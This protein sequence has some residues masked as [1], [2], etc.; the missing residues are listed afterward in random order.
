MATTKITCFPSLH[1]DRVWPKSGHHTQNS[2]YKTERHMYLKF[3]FWS[4][5]WK[6]CEGQSVFCIS[7]LQ[8]VFSEFT[9]CIFNFAIWDLQFWSGDIWEEGQRRLSHDWNSRKVTLSLLPP[10]SQILFSSV[11]ETHVILYI[12]I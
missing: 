7:N 10:H 1:S 3:S 6:F 8:I 11:Q 2:F 12:M 5:S 4:N 9:F